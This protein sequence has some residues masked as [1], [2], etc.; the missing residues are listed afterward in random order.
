MRKIP[1]LFVRDPEDQNRLTR[2]V[3]PECQWIIDDEGVALHK[4]DGTCMMLDT[5]GQ[6]WARRQ[7][8]PGRTPPPDYV[9]IE[10]DENTGK[11]FGWEPA[12]QSTYAKLWRTALHGSHEA[13]EP[14]T[15]ELVGEKINNNPEGIIGHA[16]LKHDR[17]P[18]RLDA[19]RTYDDLRDWLADYPGEG[20]VW[21]HPDGRKAKIKR[22]DVMDA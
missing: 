18:V 21:H 19:P 20:V 15:Y 16:L 4:A 8:K 2:E 17:L 6:W 5:F 22:K 10:H 11:T 9:E 7:V 13:F 1:T 12:E 14:G 3:H